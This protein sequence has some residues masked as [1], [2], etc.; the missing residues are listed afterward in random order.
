MEEVLRHERGRW[1]PLSGS[2]PAPDDNWPYR[3]RPQSGDDPQY[4]VKRPKM[5]RHLYIRRDQVLYDI[6]AQIGMLSD[7]RRQSDGSIRTFP[8]HRP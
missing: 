1:K 5:E 4:G 3:R 6:D 2:R 7:G 8:Y